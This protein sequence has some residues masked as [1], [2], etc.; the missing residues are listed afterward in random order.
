[1]P[2]SWLKIPKSVNVTDFPLSS[3]QYLMYFGQIVLWL[4]GRSSDRW[5]F[6]VEILSSCCGHGGC[7]WHFLA[8]LI[9][10]HSLCGFLYN[11]PCCPP[12]TPLQLWYI[13]AVM[14]GDCGDKIPSKSKLQ[15]AGITSCAS[16]AN[17]LS[18]R[19]CVRYL[20]FWTPNSNFS[21]C[22]PWVLR[23]FYKFVGL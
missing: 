3:V 10:H 23:M 15:S 9:V 6:L 8:P 21:S 1:M 5:A 11:L 12:M 7:H 2:T 20:Q 17:L 18:F 4:Q 19:C 13:L 16:P 14:A 22:F